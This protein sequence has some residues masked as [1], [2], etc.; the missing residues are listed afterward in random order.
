MAYCRSTW[1]LVNS[2]S[3]GLQII[4]ISDRSFRHTM[5]L[6]CRSRG[7]E[8]V[9]PKKYRVSWRDPPMT[10]NI[11][12]QTKHPLCVD[13]RFAVF[14]ASPRRTLGVDGSIAPW[15]QQLQSHTL[16]MVPV[17]WQPY[18]PPSYTSL[19]K[20]VRFG[21]RTLYVKFVLILAE[22]IRCVE[23]NIKMKWNIYFVKHNY[24]MFH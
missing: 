18:V 7:T 23:Y 21:W 24:L 6:R 15:H 16:P 20:N 12:M 8:L 1:A 14:K 2:I 3:Q 5:I 19:S 10:R 9:L 17:P 13:Y 4:R 22:D 11:K